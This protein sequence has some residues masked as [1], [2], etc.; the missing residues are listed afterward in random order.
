MVD[1]AG[2]S[3]SPLDTLTA[4]QREALELLLQHKTSKE[5]AQI[6]GISPHT[7]DQRI[8]GAKEK[9]GAATRGDLAVIYRRLRS[10]SGRMTYE[11]SHIELPPLS[12]DPG[13]GNGAVVE[14]VASDPVGIEGSRNAGEQADYR[15]VPEMFDGRYGTITRV[16]AIVLLAVLIL[17]LVL[18]GLAL[19]AQSSQFLDK[20]YD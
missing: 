19:F 5:I 16:G 20:W 8:D 17:L 3:G 18:G 15:V 2:K 12:P 1:G 9:L 6:L 13:F 4:K 14:R 7:V 10:I 11:D